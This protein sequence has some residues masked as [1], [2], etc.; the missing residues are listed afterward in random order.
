MI[1]I[2][3]T[4]NGIRIDTFLAD[5]ETLSEIDTQPRKTFKEEEQIR[6]RLFDILEHE[7]RLPDDDEEI[8][9]VTITSSVADFHSY[10]NMRN[11]HE[12]PMVVVLTETQSIDELYIKTNIEYKGKRVMT[13][14]LT[15]IEKMIAEDRIELEGFKSKDG[16]VHKID[17]MLGG[18]YDSL[19][20]LSVGKQE[21][22]VK[23][24]AEKLLEQNDSNEPKLRKEFSDNQY[25]KY[26]RDTFF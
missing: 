17:K 23:K 15:L 9:K 12:L 7:N 21:I 2:E 22:D 10:K 3:E 16:E 11:N 1:D 14:N 20:T 4:V 6:Q 5:M 18:D 13:L 24:C 25:E 8:E 26:Y 19:G